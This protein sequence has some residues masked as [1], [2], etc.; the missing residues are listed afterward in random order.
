MPFGTLIRNHPARVAVAALRDAERAFERA[1]VGP[2]YG[3]GQRTAS[4]FAPRLQA[5]ESE[6]GYAITAELPGVDAGD[7]EVTIEDG[8]LTLAGVRRTPT[9]SEDMSDEEK[10]RH[11]VSFRR[12]VRFNG[13]IDEPAVSARHRNGLLTITVPKPT[14][15]EPVIKTIPIDVA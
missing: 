13:E 9:W 10:A 15:P 8:V 1:H 2:V 7:L 11:E 3:W 6:T 5:D 14:P 4:A 12:R